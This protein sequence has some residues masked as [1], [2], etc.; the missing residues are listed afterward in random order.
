[1]RL[2]ENTVYIN[3]KTGHYCHIKEITRYLDE[4][5]SPAWIVCSEDCE[6]EEDSKTTVGRQ[7]FKAEGFKKVYCREEWKLKDKRNPHK[8]CDV[9]NTVVGEYMYLEGDVKRF[10]HKILEDI[11]EISDEMKCGVHNNLK[12][13]INKRA[14]L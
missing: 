14:G 11:E 13:I 3:K 5:E 7:I 6:F 12:R 10:V 2:Y 9:K 4:K 1:M 8:Y